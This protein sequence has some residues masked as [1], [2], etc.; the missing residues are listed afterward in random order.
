M[1]FFSISFVSSIKTITI[2]RFCR[3]YTEKPSPIP[4]AHV[5]THTFIRITSVTRTYGQDFTISQLNCKSTNGAKNL[6]VQ[7][8]ELAQS[9]Q[10]H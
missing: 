1:R 4:F 2:S 8:Y 5:H 9:N 10:P 3:N 6:T 7:K